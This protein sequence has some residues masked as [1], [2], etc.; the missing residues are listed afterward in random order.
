MTTPNDKKDRRSQGKRG[1][2][3]TGDARKGA[4][5]Q[6]SDAADV[7][8]AASSGDRIVSVEPEGGAQP[9]TELHAAANDE[10]RAALAERDQYLDHLQR[11]KAEF[12][13]YRKRVQ[14]DNQA[15][16]LRAG[17]GVLESLLPVLDNMQ[18]ALESAQRHE[19][20]QL[21]KGV[22]IVSGQLRS[23]LEGHGLDQVPA[24]PG[25]PFD[26][27]IHEAVV[28]QES[29]EFDEGAIVAVL[30][31]GYLLHGRLLRPARVVVAR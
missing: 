25:L 13:N 26:P 7:K 4:A 23:V 5:D 8:P 9:V 1:D 30:E 28:T 21:I 20:G 22:E 27:N 19:E 24:A 17:E 16:V 15:L 6:P 12:E 10:L 18:R 29:D 11:L 3:E 31:P 2:H 14:R